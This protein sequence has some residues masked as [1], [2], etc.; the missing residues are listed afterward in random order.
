MSNVPV[1]PTSDLYDE[2][3]ESLE[4]CDLP[5]R[6]YGGLTAFQGEIV[7]V[8]A[9]QDNL[10][11]KQVVAEPGGGRVIVVDT[12]GVTRVAMLG[13]NM[14]AQALANGWT[15]V[16]V[17]GAVRDV[18][19]LREIPLGIMALGSSPRR[20]RKE[21]AGERDVALSFGGATF[22]PGALLVCDEDGV[23]VLTAAAA[24]PGAPST[25]AA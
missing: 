17:N 25:P 20:S 1:T 22:E 8:R 6:S 12:D 9:H 19:A 2:H 4:C 10:L 11:L 18:A 15:G 16:L 5:W 7:T 13:D 24:R 14:A 3:L 21:G 23:V